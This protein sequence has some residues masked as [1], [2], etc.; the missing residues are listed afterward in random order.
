MKQK[1]AKKRTQLVRRVGKQL[2]RERYKR[3]INGFLSQLQ[4]S[5]IRQ[6]CLNECKKTLKE[7]HSF[8]Q[9]NRDSFCPEKYTPSYLGSK[10][11]E[12]NDSPTE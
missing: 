2:E 5:K 6:C 4:A 8:F 3:L 11:C 7:A 10:L 12:S 1:D 9:T